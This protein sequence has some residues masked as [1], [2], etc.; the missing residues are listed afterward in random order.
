MRGYLGTTCSPG[1]LCG[2][3]SIEFAGDIEDPPAV[4]AASVQHLRLCVQS[5]RRSRI[6][7]WAR[8]IPAWAGLAE[9]VPCWPTYS[10]QMSSQLSRVTEYFARTRLDYELFWTGNRD[11]ALHHGYY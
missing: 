8:S 7:G 2:E 5:Y 4:L 11:Q 10:P 9:V 6:S 1:A 3:P